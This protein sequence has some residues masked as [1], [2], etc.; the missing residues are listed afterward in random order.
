MDDRISTLRKRKSLPGSII[1]CHSRSTSRETSSY[2]RRQGKRFLVRTVIEDDNAPDTSNLWDKI[3]E[4]IISEAVVEANKKRD[5]L[6]LDS[7][8]VL[9]Y[10]C[11]SQIRDSSL[12]LQLEK[13]ERNNAACGGVLS[14]RYS[15]LR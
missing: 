2:Q 14:P 13:N 15:Q 5:S 10:S 9:N 7:I 4:F 3:L 8:N 12:Y 1:F 11:Q 6:F